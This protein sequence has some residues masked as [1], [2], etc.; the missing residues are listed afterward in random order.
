M[1]TPLYESGAVV[2][3]AEGACVLVVPC[4]MTEQI[5]QGI[6]IKFCVKL[7][8]SSAETMIQ[9]AQLWATG[10]WQLHHDNAPAHASHF[11]QSFLAKHQ[12]P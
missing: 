8:H 4:K 3:T 6:C 2:G 11:T 12:I 5:E 1:I 10:D 7:E 9:K